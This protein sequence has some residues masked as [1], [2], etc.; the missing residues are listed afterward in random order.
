MVLGREEGIRGEEGKGE[1]GE[2][3]RKEGRGRRRR[4]DIKGRYK[5]ERRRRSVVWA[6]NGVACRESC[7]VL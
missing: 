4:S 1:E 2:G 7:S 6:M 3:E 5:G